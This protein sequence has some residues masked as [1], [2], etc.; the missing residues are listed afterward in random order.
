MLLVLLILGLL[1]ALLVLFL[2]HGSVLFGILALVCFGAGTGLYCFRKKLPGKLGTPL[3][4]LC[5]LL[6][7]AALFFCGT[8]KA[9]KGFG[10]YDQ[11]LADARVALEKEDYD[12]AVELLEEVGGSYEPDDN[13][14]LLLA[15]KDLKQEDYA[16]AYEEAEQFKDRHSVAY[17][18]LVEWICI[19]DPAP[20]S[21]ERVYALYEE[22]AAQWPDWTYMQL[23]AGISLFEQGKYKKAQYYL[24]RASGLDPEDA[25]GSY[26][27]GACF[28]H[29]SDYEKCRYYFNE[30]IERGADDTIKGNIMWYMDKMQQAGGDS[31]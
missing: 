9:A 14:H 18:V 2:F 16:A 26:Y 13:V 28:F 31:E 8:T 20:E 1:F 27:L 5:L 25:V 29:Q 12:K 30:A 3:A 11:L 7:A 21:V 6:G 15:L 17:Y 24:L 10:A 22:A 4:L 19:L 23:Y